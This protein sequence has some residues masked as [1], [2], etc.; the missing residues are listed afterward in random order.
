MNLLLDTHVF[1]WAVSRPHALS[2]A[3]RKALQDP[4]NRVL[5]SVVSAWEISIK[6]SLGKLDAPSDLRQILK[7][8]DVEELPLHLRHTEALAGLAPLHRDPFDRMLVAQALA[9]GLTLVTR[10][11]IL[12]RYGVPILSA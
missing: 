12:K 11:D 8:N 2:A 5:F 10:D 6:K 1:L 3:A 9:D 4:E 7:L